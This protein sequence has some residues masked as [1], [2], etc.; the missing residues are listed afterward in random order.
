MRPHN[1]NFGGVVIYT[2]DSLLNVVL[3]DDLMLTKLCNCS[4]CEFE[5]L[6]IEF[7]YNG[8]SY[9]LGG[10]YRHPSGDVTYFVS[11]V[12]TI[13]TKL[14]DRK[15]V[16]LAGDM[17]I[18]LIKHTNDNVI[19]FIST[20]M[21]YRYLPDVTPLTRITQFSTTCIDNIFVR[22]VLLWYKRPLAMFHSTPVCQ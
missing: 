1:N 17:N 20:M 12:E 7:M 15:N 9:T 16:I 14:D 10:I 18:D 19:S 13:L 3:R 8:L 22:H 2:H 6:F 11:S 5:S 4:K 21:S